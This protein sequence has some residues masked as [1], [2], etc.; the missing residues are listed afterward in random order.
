MTP[1][2]GFARRGHALYAQASRLDEAQLVERHAALL[3]RMARR[4]CFRAAM[5]HA[6][7]DLWSAGALGLL[8][9]ARRFDAAR[10]VRFETFAEHR[11]RGAMLDELRRLDHLPRRLRA[12]LDRLQAARRELAEKLGRE[13]D[14]AELAAALD[15][16]VEEVGEL[17]ALLQPVVPIDEATV[18]PSPAPLQEELLDRARLQGRLAQAIA[19]L[20]ERQQLVVSLRY[21]EG[22]SNKEVAQVLGVSEPR[23]CQIHGEA[24]KRL[25]AALAEDR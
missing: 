14:E 4:L 8:D 12:D 7:D 13:P 10:D 25:R 23:V 6:F 2:G 1:L 9:A 20:P 11:V 15:L 24:T 17:A 5:H 21:V 22:L 19:A 3:D 16:P 18:P